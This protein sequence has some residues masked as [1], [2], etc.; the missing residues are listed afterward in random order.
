MVIELTESK[1]TSNKTEGRLLIDRI[2]TGFSIHDGD[3]KNTKNSIKF[4]L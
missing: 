3:S 1:A 4:R 2:E